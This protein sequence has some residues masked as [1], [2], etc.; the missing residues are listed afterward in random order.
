MKRIEENQKESSGSGDYK[1]VVIVYD[2]CLWQHRQNTNHVITIKLRNYAYKLLG[3]KLKSKKFSYKSFPCLTFS[4]K[5]CD[6]DGS[7]VGR[8]VAGVVVVGVVVGGVVVG[9]GVVGHFLSLIVLIVCDP[10]VGGQTLMLVLIRS[11]I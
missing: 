5:A 7:L 10:L 9:G 8:V 3:K 1:K 4:Q 6:A 2:I 11:L